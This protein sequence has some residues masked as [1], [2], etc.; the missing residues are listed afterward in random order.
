M[1]LILKTRDPKY[2]L[3]IAKQLLRYVH[4]SGLGS[5][6]MY[7]RWFA[8]YRRQWP[9]EDG[10][11]EPPIRNG[12]WDS[13]STLYCFVVGYADC[14]DPVT[15]KVVQSLADGVWPVSRFE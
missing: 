13:L 15:G 9:N 8:E 12:T 14:T 5:A 7:T 2:E 11:Y 4:P 3:E 6:Y 10:I 1:M